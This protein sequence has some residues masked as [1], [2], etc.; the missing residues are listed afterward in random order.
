MVK[1][2]ASG[3]IATDIELKELSNDFYV[4]KFRL[5]TKNMRAKKDDKDKL[6][7]FSVSVFG[8]PA[9]ILHSKMCK[10]CHIV[11]D[12]EL[13]S[14]TRT[15]DGKNRDFVEITSNNMVEFVT[16]PDSLEDKQSQPQQQVAQQQ[17]APQAAQPVQQPVQQTWSDQTTDPFGDE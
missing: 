1:C 10:G 11:V 3:V 12:G 4:A 15:I 17:P 14:N 8:K 9:V 7:F 16:W 6:F 13:T 2:I 5:S